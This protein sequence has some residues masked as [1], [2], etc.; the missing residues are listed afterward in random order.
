MNNIIIIIYGL[1]LASGAYFGWKAG[2]KPSLIAGSA[3]AIL[4]FIGYFIAQSNPKNGYM[5]LS[6]VSAVLVI[7]FIKRLLATGKFMPSGML[8]AVTIAFLAFCLHNISRI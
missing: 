3:S 6:I 2:S 5:M 8:L 4:V 7:V 1:F